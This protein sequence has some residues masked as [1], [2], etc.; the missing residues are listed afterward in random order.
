V[1]ERRRITLSEQDGA[2]ELVAHMDWLGDDVLVQLVGGKGH[3]GAIGIGQTRSSLKDA[4]GAASTSSVF[5]VIG[6]KEDEIAKKMAGDLSRALHCT[7]VVVAGMHWDG[8]GQAD[9]DRIVG[10]CDK[11]CRKLVEQA[12]GSR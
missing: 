4:A 2:F 9:I 1:Q 8:L 6:H 10:M 11:I 3:I 7:A 12:K 5:A